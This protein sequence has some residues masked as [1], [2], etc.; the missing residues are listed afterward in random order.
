M[1]KGAP[2]RGDATPSSRG[3][4]GRRPLSRSLRFYQRLA[5]GF[6]VVTLFLLV[7]VLYLS[8]SRAT[9]HVV[10]NPK[11]VSENLTVAVVPNPAVEGEMTGIVVEETVSKAQTFTLPSE[12]GTPVEQKAGG[13]VTLINK[14]GTAQP[15]VTTTRLLSEEG[16]LFRIDDSV[17][18]PANGTVD[19]T[20]HADEPGL[21]GEIGAT[22]FTIPG[23][24]V[25]LQDDIYAVSVEPMTGGV[26]YVRVLTEQD[27]NDA[28][29][30]L[31]DE[32]LAETTSLLAE[33]VDR[34]EFTGE[35]YAMEVLERKSDTQPGAE[36]GQF[37]VSLSA[38]VTGVYFND[39]LLGSYAQSELRTR[40]PIGY[41]M[42]NVN[43]DGMQVTIASADEA[44][45]NASLDVYLDGTGHIAEDSEVLNK[46]RFVGRSAQEVVTLLAASEA[47]S[48]SYVT[49]T[50][51]WLKRVPTLKDHITIEIESFVE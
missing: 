45:G 35:A 10:P 25:S 6:V 18:V 23:L 44:K 9:I 51:F 4:A 20:A 5:V 39:A 19:V 32:M 22:Q 29:T 48:E 41:E 26:Q 49:F 14:T 11:L 12:G 34:A 38:R 15:L 2:K 13:V 8:L 16:V 37:I 43:T 3:G 50:P 47:V 36:A 30:L 31:S 24:P 28:V 27:L 40:L 21:A 42:T 7:T 33:G 46:D 17:T 1:V